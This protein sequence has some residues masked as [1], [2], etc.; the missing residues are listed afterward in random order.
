[1]AD[2][3]QWLQQSAHIEKAKQEMVRESL[4]DYVMHNTEFKLPLG[5]LKDKGGDMQQ[6]CS[7]YYKR[8]E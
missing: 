5:K 2:I 3:Y 8:L 1:M 7:F 6:F 4:H